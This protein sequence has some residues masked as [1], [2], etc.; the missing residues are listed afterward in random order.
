MYKANLRAY[1]VLPKIGLTVFALGKIFV[2][3]CVI[4]D[5]IL[6]TVSLVLF[7]KSEHGVK[8]DSFFIALFRNFVSSFYQKNSKMKIGLSKRIIYC[9]LCYNIS[10]IYDCIRSV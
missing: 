3:M 6:A 9:L 7:S 2:F 1:S 8:V 10:V 4:K 5:S